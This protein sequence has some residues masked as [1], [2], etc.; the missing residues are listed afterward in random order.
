M[1]LRV[2]VE[3]PTKLSKVGVTREMFP[4]IIEETMAYRL[5]AIN[6]IKI[7]PKIVEDILNEAY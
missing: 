5:L 6:P 7:T 1:I 2:I 4:Q 3:I